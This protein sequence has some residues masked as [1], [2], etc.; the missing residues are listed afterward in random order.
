MSRCYTELNFDFWDEHRPGISSSGEKE[1]EDVCED[2][3]QYCKA[4]REKR[5]MIAVIDKVRITLHEVIMQFAG[6]NR[7]RA[8]KMVEALL[9]GGEWFSLFSFLCS[10]LA[11]GCE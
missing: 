9:H 8:E 7:E 2:Y 4:K 6:G 11:G 3:E 5:V 1:W 10:C